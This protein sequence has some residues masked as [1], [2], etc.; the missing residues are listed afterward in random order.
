M[1]TMATS[2]GESHLF[3]QTFVLI[4]VILHTAVATQP[5]VKNA[6][7][8]FSKNASSHVIGRVPN[9]ASSPTTSTALLLKEQLNFKTTRAISTS[10][11]I[12]RKTNILPPSPSSN[13]PLLKDVLKDDKEHVKQ[14]RFVKEHD[15]AKKTRQNQ[16]NKFKRK[17]LIENKKVRGRGKKLKSQK[18]LDRK[19]RLK[20]RRNLNQKN[21]QIRI[22]KKYTSHAGDKQQHHHNHHHDDGG[23]DKQQHHHNHH[24]HG[25]K[26]K[27]RQQ[28][29]LSSTSASPSTPSTATLSHHH[30]RV[31]NFSSPIIQNTT[32]L[33]VHTTNQ[34]PTKTSLK[35]QA[36]HLDKGKL[37]T[38]EKKTVLKSTDKN[39][40]RK[41]DGDDDDDDK[42]RNNGF[43]PLHDS[44]TSPHSPSS[45]L[46][47]NVMVAD[48]GSNVGIFSGIEPKISMM[49][50]AWNED[51]IEANF[52]TGKI[53]QMIFLK[54]V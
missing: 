48:D 32:T 45:I 3:I 34:N 43:P 9:S 31:S 22:K 12:E 51:K 21:T 11:D 8:T 28:Q 49:D 25:G 17:R 37:A 38:S 6:S 30:I 53:R 40:H 27:M 14:S 2:V 52:M 39:A 46:S 24:H 23:G 15:I 13:W 50:Y 5:V 16:R 20:G 54:H 33:K 36:S 47:E 29:K 26:R 44:N 19:S 7:F 41:D 1:T 42:E 18:L 35:V 4:V 10:K